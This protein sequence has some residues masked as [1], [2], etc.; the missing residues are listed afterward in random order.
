M[1]QFNIE[2]HNRII[3]QIESHPETWD[4]TLWHCG[5]TRCYGGWAAVLCG[6]S[7]NPCVIKSAISS[8]N[9]T[10]RQANYAFGSARTLEELKALPEYVIP[11]IEKAAHP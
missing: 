4:Q 6:A 5:T 10:E 3:Q 7:W 2:L 9:L 8:L 11:K 1:K